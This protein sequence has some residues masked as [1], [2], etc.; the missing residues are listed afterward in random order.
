MKI[1]SFLNLLCKGFPGIAIGWIKTTIVAIRAATGTLAPVPVGTGKTGIDRH[2][3]NPSA[4]FH[5]NVFGVGVKPPVVIPGE[6][7]LGHDQFL[8]LPLRREGTKFT[9][10]YFLLFK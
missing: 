2:F 10:T 1:Y 9:D 6:Q 3:L 5:F 7:G 4:E 8:L